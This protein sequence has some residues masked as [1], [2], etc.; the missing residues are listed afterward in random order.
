V[1][2]P[3][4]QRAADLGGLLIAAGETER[5]QV[6]LEAAIADYEQEYVRGVANWPMGIAK[7]EALA[8]LGRN[9][10]AI[11]ELQRVI[12]DGWRLLWQWDT[13]F[14]PS[15]DGLRDD[16]RFDELVEYMEMDLAEQVRNFEEPQ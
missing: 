6:L 2:A 14:N 11:V 10:E 4:V 1:V 16:P 3:F 12:D 5:G 9:D 8:Q 13:I 15:F 7:A